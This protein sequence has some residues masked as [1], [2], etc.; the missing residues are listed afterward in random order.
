MNPK[1]I[2][3]SC[4]QHGY[5]GETVDDILLQDYRYQSQ[6]TTMIDHALQFIKQQRLHLDE[7]I[8]QHEQLVQQTNQ[9]WFKE[10]NTIFYS[11]DYYYSGNGVVTIS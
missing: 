2:D 3:R 7:A 8:T 11:Y 9:Q 5:R 6:C 4:L 10:F 1:G